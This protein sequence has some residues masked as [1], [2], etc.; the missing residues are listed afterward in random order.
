MI[1]GAMSEVKKTCQLSLDD[2]EY[3]DIK[4]IASRRNMTVE[5]WIEATVS[6]ARVD[7]HRRVERIRRVIE[8]TSHL[9]FPTA[10][11]E[12]MLKEIESGYLDNGYLEE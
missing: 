8:E 5:Q 9:N 12:D 7:Y 10:D 3:E 6:E 1:K 4:H 11:I 2:A